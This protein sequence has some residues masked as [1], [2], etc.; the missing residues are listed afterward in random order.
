[1]TTYRAIASTEVDG[2]SP[3]TES[4]AQAWTDNL[5]AT[6]EGDSTAPEMVSKAIKPNI[7]FKT[8]GTGSTGLVKFSGFS[9]WGGVEITLDYK[10][11]ASG[12][13]HDIDID[14]SDNDTTYYGS[15][16][17]RSAADSDTGRIHIIVDFETENVE[18]AGYAGDANTNFTGSGT[19]TGTT[20]ASTNYVRIS[21]TAST[22]TDFV[23][24]LKRW[25][26]V[27]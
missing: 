18:W 8:T 1:M 3:I 16:T 21:S 24:K 17:V 20:Y 27:A 14:F 26:A 11:P 15:V 23:A 12:G 19:S 10:V 7:A 2:Q 25:R 4:L 5:V 6:A 22:G 9:G 13:P